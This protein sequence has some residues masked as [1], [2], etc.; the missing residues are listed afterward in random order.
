MHQSAVEASELDRIVVAQGGILY[1][2]AF[3][4]DCR[5]DACLQFK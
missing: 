4:S 1:R 5:E 3:S 2:I